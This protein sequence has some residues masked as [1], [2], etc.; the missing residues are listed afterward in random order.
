MSVSMHPLVRGI[1][2]SSWKKLSSDRRKFENRRA[3]LAFQREKAR[4][5]AKNGI[6]PQFDEVMEQSLRKETL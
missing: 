1:A 5:D 4:Q 2:P 3:V 6:Q